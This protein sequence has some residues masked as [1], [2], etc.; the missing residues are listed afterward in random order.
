MD[1]PLD[2]DTLSFDYKSDA[3]PDTVE[4]H[5][6]IFYSKWKEKKKENTFVDYT[7]KGRVTSVYEFSGIDNDEKTQ[8][9]VTLKGSRDLEKVRESQKQELGQ[10]KSLLEE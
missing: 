9:D 10:I 6:N 4:K 1:L 2:E 3:S 8:I 5:V 7:R